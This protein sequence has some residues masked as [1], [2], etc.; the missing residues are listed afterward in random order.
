MTA[1]R[2]LIP[3]FFIAKRLHSLTGL[4]LVIFIIEHLLTNSQAALFWGDDG[5][6]FI[7]SVNFI[8]NLSY[9]KVIEVLLLLVPIIYHGFWGIVVAR[10]AKFNVQDSSGLKPQLS[11]YGRNWAYTFQRISSWILLFGIAFHVIQMRFINRPEVIGF[12]EDKHY[13]VK[14]SI[15]KGLYVLASRWGINL[16]D[17]KEINEEEILYN[18]RLTKTN[19][20]TTIDLE[21][22]F[23]PKVESFFKQKDSLEKEKMYID[24]LK[25][26]ELSKNDVIASCP[27]FGVAILLV[28]RDTFKDP[29]MIALYTL[30]VLSATFHAFNGLWSF[31]ISFG[32]TITEKSQRLALAFSQVLMCIVSLLGLMA[33]FGSYYLGF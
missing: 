33:I 24:K 2:L 32:F 20:A 10:K 15:D 27:S 31:M 26:F 1:K 4:F 13:V 23:D 6:G 22:G 3:K 18:N 12:A 25:G 11:N 19:K 9:L 14:V 5:A 28:V 29:V 8:F 21:R 16:I 30:F 7:K 17:D